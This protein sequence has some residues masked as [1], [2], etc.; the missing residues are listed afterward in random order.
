VLT[1]QLDADLTRRL[2]SIARRYAGKPDLHEAVKM[3]QWA[4]RE[5][6]GHEL[7]RP[8]AEALLESVAIIADSDA[9]GADA[10][11]GDHAEQLLVRKFEPV[12][13]VPTLF[14]SW[15]AAC[16]D[17]GGGE[18]LARGWH[19]TVAARTGVGKSVFAL[20]SC[21]EA[22]LAGTRVFFL[23]LEM[24]QVQLETRFLAIM[25]GT[26]VRRMEQG[27]HL[28][29]AAHRAAARRLQ[30]LHDAT[31]GVFMSNR[32][33]LHSLAQVDAAVRRAVEHDDAR[34]VVLDYL[35]LAARDPNDAKETIASHAV[36]RLAQ[37]LG[38][39][40]LV[41]SQ[42]NR[43]TSKLDIRPSVHGLMGGSAIENDSDQIVL[44]DH[45]RM[46]RAP[47]PAFGWT[48]YALLAKNR[49]GPTLEIPMSF[50]SETLRITERM[51][52]EL[53]ARLAA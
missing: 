37:D 49:H 42:F 6:F 5:Q 17:E 44:I 27:P 24:S 26:P 41:L 25:S 1:T 11:L 4:A 48:G 13:A 3:M 53:P 32:R 7:D 51:P 18:G 12:D 46:E 36:R 20:N 47:A 8:A 16:R 40:T 34:L 9:V 22:L 43:E 45:S 35:Q 39:T 14:R 38:V 21:K 52:D 50:D 19:C 29:A 23:S 28:D 33:Q 10:L 15:T 30:E 31:G 2:I